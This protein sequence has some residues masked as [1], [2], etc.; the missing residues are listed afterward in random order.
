M[1]IWKHSW[2]SMSFL[3]FKALCSGDR[4]FAFY[5]RGSH[6]VEWKRTYSKYRR[7]I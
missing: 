2:A 4:Y 1:L 5:S 6:L 7:Y 3:Y